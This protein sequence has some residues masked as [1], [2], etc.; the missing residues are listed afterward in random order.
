MAVSGIA[1]RPDSALQATEVEQQGQ[2]PSLT[3]FTI[4][5]PWPAVWFA[6]QQLALQPGTAKTLPV[7]ILRQSIATMAIDRVL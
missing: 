1:E 3:I 2:A 4:A 5:F 6:T 7:K